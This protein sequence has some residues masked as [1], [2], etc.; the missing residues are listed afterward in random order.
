MDQHWNI[1]KQLFSKLRGWCGDAYWESYNFAIDNWKKMITYRYEKV[2]KSF[3][4][5][6]KPIYNEITKPIL[7]SPKIEH[8]CNLQ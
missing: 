6:N 4:E 1:L 8:A 3:I 2:D 7:T 5:T